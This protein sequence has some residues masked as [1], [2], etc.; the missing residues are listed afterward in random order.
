MSCKSSWPRGWPRGVATGWAPRPAFLQEV[1]GGQQQQRLKVCRNVK[2]M[3]ACMN[4][5]DFDVC[6]SACVYVSAYI[7]ISEYKCGYVYICLYL[8]I[9]MYVNE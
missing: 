3:F 8:C 6:V 9:Y 7:H 1:R 5:Y 4:V 2:C